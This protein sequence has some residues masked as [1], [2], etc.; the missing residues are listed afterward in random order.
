[1][2]NRSDFKWVRYK[3]RKK[4]E[5]GKDRFKNF[6]MNV[7]WEKTIG[8]TI[9]PDESVRRLHNKIDKLTNICF[10][11]K[12]YKIRSI[13]PSWINDKIR[14]RIRRRRRQYK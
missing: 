8:D 7:D 5:E 4:T 12:S 1:M 14:R 3:A 13:D 11:L 6:F 9:C 2:P 10:P